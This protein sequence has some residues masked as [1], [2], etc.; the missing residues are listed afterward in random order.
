MTRILRERTTFGKM[1]PPWH[2]VLGVGRRPGFEGREITLGEAR[3]GIF[4]FVL[5]APFK[6]EKVA[7]RRREGRERAREVESHW[8]Q[9]THGDEG[10]QH[11][12]NEED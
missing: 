8:K 12:K 10:T 7:D 11:S 1:L 5:E 4:L 3:G 2:H 9:E 6:R